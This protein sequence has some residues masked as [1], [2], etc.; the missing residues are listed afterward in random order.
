MPVW[1]MSERGDLIYYNDEAEAILGRRFN[2]AGEIR[3]EDLAELFQTTDEH[4]EPV[5]SER[6]P[7]NVAL[8]ERRAAHLPLRIRGLDGVWRRIAV[9]AFP[10][11]GKDARH[12][13]AVALFWE[14][15]E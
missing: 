6:L 11:E 2:E 15:R 1:I 3:G 7:I 4:G 12:L 13:G 8:T 10:I 14:D 9:T 5:P